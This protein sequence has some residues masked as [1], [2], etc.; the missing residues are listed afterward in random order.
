MVQHMKN[1]AQFWMLN[2][3]K[4]KDITPLDTYKIVRDFK[5]C[6]FFI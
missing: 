4:N 6:Y 2:E 3:Q 5:R 1:K